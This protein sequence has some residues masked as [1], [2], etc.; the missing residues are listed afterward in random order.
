MRADA[1][2]NRQR[3]LAAAADLF[4]AHGLAASLDDIARH[5]GVGPG[6]VHRHF[7]SK[8]GLI[9]AVALERLEALVVAAQHRA[10]AEDPVPALHDQLSEMVV[11][12]DGSAPLKQALAGTASD[13][14]WSQTD[15]SRRLRD[16]L[17][18][19]LV[20]AQRAQGVRGDLDAD[21][22][23]SLLTG[24][25]AAI[26]RARVPADSI[27]GRRL[28]SVLLAGIAPRD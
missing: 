11:A 4:A 27:V 17:G 2:A 5:A 24:C 26:Q 15:L 14:S 21:D 3:I 8:D 16:S 13:V 6:T 7:P 28:T 18:V 22:L 12:G 23:M 1:R 19:L 25:Y 9:A 10:R 20:R